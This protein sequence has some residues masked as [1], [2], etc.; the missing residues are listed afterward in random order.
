MVINDQG[1]YNWRDQNDAQG[2]QRDADK[3]KDC[4]C[5]RVG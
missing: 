1:A 4:S 3:M 5:V 2:E